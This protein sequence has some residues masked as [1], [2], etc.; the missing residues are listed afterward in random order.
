MFGKWIVTWKRMKLDYCPMPC[1]RINSNFIKDMNIRPQTIKF[2][3]DI[4]YF[5]SVVAIS[6]K[7]PNQQT[8]PKWDYIRL[9]TFCPRQQNA[10]TACQLGEDVCKPCVCLETNIQNIWSTHTTQQ[11]V[12]H[13]SWRKINAFTLKWNIFKNKKRK[14]PT[15]WAN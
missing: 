15:K 6:L 1:K 14:T 8:K 5:L 2:I 10:K 13:V 9:N 3:E 11:Q 12:R 4:V 7:K